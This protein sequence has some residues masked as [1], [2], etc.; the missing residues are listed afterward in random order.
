MN[1]T[2]ADDPRA[3]YL[4]LMK[5]VLTNW[6]YGE[7]ECRPLRLR[8]L[9]GRLRRAAVAAIAGRRAFLVR[10]RPFDPGARAEGRDWPPSAHTMIGLRRLD[11]L[12]RCVEEVLREDVPGDLIEAGVWRGGAAVFMR[13]ILEAH[14]A[15]ERRVWVADSFRGLPPPDPRFPADRGSK[16]HLR[17]SLRISLEEVRANFQR[18]GLL[19]DQVRFL[20]GW[21]KDTLPAAPIEKLAVARLDGDL[22]ESTLTS[23]QCLYPKLSPGGFLIV[24]DYGAIPACR[25]AVADF[26]RE[27]GITEEI[28]P[29]DWTG[30]F[31][32]RS[33]GEVRNK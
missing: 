12:Q 13:A 4:D 22:Y 25:Q 5:K 3:L 27:H 23:L 16:F 31:W 30:A 8:G 7:T 1:V 9:R 14:G 17:A 32:K 29:I 33:S 11:N 6:I 10:P 2:P 20:E 18:Y 28:Q 26:R 21:F 24:D 15:R 19:D